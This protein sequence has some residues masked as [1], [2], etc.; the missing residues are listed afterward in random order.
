M[1]N[2]LAKE[3]I[4]PVINRG[5]TWNRYY[6]NVVIRSAC[7]IDV[8]LESGQLK[9]CEKVLNEND[10]NRHQ[11]YS[12][13]WFKNGVELD[14]HDCIFG[15][16]GKSYFQKALNFPYLEVIANSRF[17]YLDDLFSIHRN[18]SSSISKIHIKTS[19]EL[20]S[21]RLF[22]IVDDFIYNTI[23]WVSH[24]Y[25][26]MRRGVDLALVSDEITYLN[27]WDDVI[28]RSGEYRLERIFNCSVIPLNSIF[29][30]NL[31][32]LEIPGN[33]GLTKLENKLIGSISAGYRIPFCG[34]Y[35]LANESRSFFKKMQFYMKGVLPNRVD[36]HAD[37]VRFPTIP[38]FFVPI[39]RLMRVFR[40]GWR[41]MIYRFK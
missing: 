32:V 13:L 30:L 20:T 23:H 35:L 25:E 39:F 2:S 21:I 9:K 10:W 40:A 26:L 4:H 24:S 16:E 8:F 28:R 19:H 31:P 37:A 14:L 34:K 27:K 6:K 29:N 1:L 5:I 33:G 38:L 17:H 18:D 12:H 15:I 3:N 22:D 36:M 11:V 41:L 7:D